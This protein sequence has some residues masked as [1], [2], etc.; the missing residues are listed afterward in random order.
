MSI[1]EVKNF[2]AIDEAKKTKSRKKRTKI[3]WVQA[4]TLLA[5]IVLTLS[6]YGDTYHLTEEPDKL[7]AAIRDYIPNVKAEVELVQKEAEWMYVIFS[8]PQYGD[9]FMGLALLKRGWNHKYVLRSAQYGSGPPIQLENMVGNHNQVIIYGMIKDGR[10][11]RYEYAKEIQDIY[12]E[13]MYRGN[14]D[15]EVFF[16]VQDNKG[17]WYWMAPF[18]L[19][20]DEGEDIMDSYLSQQRRD[21]PAGGVST[22]ELFM[23]DVACLFIIILGILLTVGVGRKLRHEN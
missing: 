15:Q 3:R 18:Q 21:A 23:V 13:V 11:V 14:I 12:R 1:D 5:T 17:Y 16:H 9:C 2:Y 19:F 4:L 7:E 8:D 20:N 22:A 6:I 10:A